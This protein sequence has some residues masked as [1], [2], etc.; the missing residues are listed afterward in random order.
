MRMCAF[1]NGMAATNANWD[2]SVA[3]L[4]GQCCLDR[5]IYWARAGVDRLGSILE[6]RGML[7]AFRGPRPLKRFLLAQTDAKK[8]TVVTH[9]D[10]VCVGEYDE[11]RAGQ[12]TVPRGIPF[13]RRAVS[14]PLVLDAPRAR[15]L[16]ADG[17]PLQPSLLVLLLCGLPHRPVLLGSTHFT[18]PL[19]MSK[20]VRRHNLPCRCIC[21]PVPL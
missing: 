14:H 12:G 4:D 18:S 6:A 11:D 20:H 1:P 2:S 16:R 15:H 5:V 8:N 10:A 9:A 21:G 17:V 7:R 19:L 13:L 3:G